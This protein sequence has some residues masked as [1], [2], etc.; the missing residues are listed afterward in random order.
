MDDLERNAINLTLKHEWMTVYQAKL[1][2]HDAYMRYKSQSRFGGW[3]TV[4]TLI[5][6]DYGIWW[7]SSEEHM[8]A[9]LDLLESRMD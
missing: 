3:K 7:R 2:L 5:G 9:R 8:R 4:E 1:L 6:I